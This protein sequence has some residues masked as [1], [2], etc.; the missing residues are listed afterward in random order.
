MEQVSRVRGQ[1]AGVSLYDRSG[2]RPG[3]KV[4]IREYCMCGPIRTGRSGSR[5]ATRTGQGVGFTGGRSGSRRGH[6]EVRK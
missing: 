4:L 3:S 6:R 2:H 1:R 5:Q